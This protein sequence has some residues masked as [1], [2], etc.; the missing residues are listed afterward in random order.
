ME[1]GGGEGQGITLRAE[2][3]DGN[4]EWGLEREIRS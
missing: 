3:G 4:G 2:D 1:T